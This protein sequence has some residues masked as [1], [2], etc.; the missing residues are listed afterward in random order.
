MSQGFLYWVPSGGLTP[1]Q[2]ALLDDVC[3][4]GRSFVDSEGPTGEPGRLYWNNGTVTKPFQRFDA[5]AQE[6]CLHDNVWCGM[7]LEM[8]PSP[9]VLER[10]PSDKKKCPRT[11]LVNLDGQDQPWALPHVFRQDGEV[12]LKTHLTFVENGESVQVEPRVLRV[13]MPLYHRVSRMRDGVVLPL[14]DG[15]KPDPD[16]EKDVLFLSVDLLNHQYAINAAGV[17]LLE[18]LQGDNVSLIIGAA[19]GVVDVLLGGMGHKPEVV[20]G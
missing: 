1:Q 20:D 5:Q 12:L 2:N 10:P 8:T 19:T 16:A 3:P 15:D 7:W 11:Y 14:A 13:H 6:W 9:S 17:T 4:R 18:L